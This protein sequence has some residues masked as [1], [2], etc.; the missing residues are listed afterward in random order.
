MA[1]GGVDD[2]GSE[3]VGPLAHSNDD[4]EGTEKEVVELNHSSPR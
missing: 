2:I 3:E 1:S 4:I